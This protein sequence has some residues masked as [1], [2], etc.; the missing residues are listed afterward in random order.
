MSEGIKSRA[1]DIPDELRDTPFYRWVQ[2][3]KGSGRVSVE[4]LSGISDQQQGALNAKFAEAKKWY[5]RS[6]EN[7]F[8]PAAN[9]LAVLYFNA[10]GNDRDL[11]SAKIFLEQAAGDGNPVAAMNLMV[12]GDYVPSDRGGPSEL[13]KRFSPKDA[14]PSD[15]V[16]P[17]FGRTL[18]LFGKIPEAERAMMRAAAKQG[19]PVKQGAPVKFGL[20]PL[21][22]D[23]SLPTFDDV[24]KGLRERQ[25]P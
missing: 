23:P 7:G 2:S 20:R 5:R 1:G 18:R 16:E 19:D 25:G 13:V 14:A 11:R 9:N 3:S 21:T 17:T 4:E 24:R 15:L 6:A 12:L 22:P 8:A 10:S